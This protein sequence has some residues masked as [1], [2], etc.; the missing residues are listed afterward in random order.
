MNRSTIAIRLGL[1]FAWLVFAIPYGLLWSRCMEKTQHK[2]LVIVV[3]FVGLL[4]VIVAL[5]LVVLMMRR[6]EG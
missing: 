5:M 2:W 3:G 1:F 6:L 4:G